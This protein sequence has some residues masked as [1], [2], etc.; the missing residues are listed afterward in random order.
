MIDII[1]WAIT[2]FLVLAFMLSLISPTS[3]WKEIWEGIKKD[4]HII[5]TKLLLLL[6]VI[7]TNMAKDSQLLS[8][9]LG[10]YPRN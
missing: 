7:E 6:T 1:I 10:E 2:L 4:A 3:E 5:H 8:I 9:Y